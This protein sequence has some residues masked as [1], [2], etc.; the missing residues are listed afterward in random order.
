MGVGSRYLLSFLETVLEWFVRFP[1][2]GK[3]GLP[4]SIQILRV[5]KSTRKDVSII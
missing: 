4:S 5:G 2:L 1:V 3:R